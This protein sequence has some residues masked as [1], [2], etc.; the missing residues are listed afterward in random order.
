MYCTN[1]IELIY[2]ICQGSQTFYLSWLLIISFNCVK[3]FENYV[4]VGIYLN[5]FEILLQCLLSHYW[6]RLWIYFLLT[7]LLFKLLT[8][9]IIILLFFSFFCCCCCKTHPYQNGCIVWLKL[10]CWDDPYVWVTNTCVQFRSDVV[11][12]NIEIQLPCGLIDL[13]KTHF[14][15]AV[16]QGIKC[17]KVWE[18]WFE[19]HL[20]T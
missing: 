20:S 3:L 11:S 1:W 17:A 9:I 8:G 6:I 10:W 12:L 19:I 15:G 18:V 7:F 16:F 4:H 5:L 2:G 13:I 14:P